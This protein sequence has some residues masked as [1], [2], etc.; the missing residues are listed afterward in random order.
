VIILLETRALAEV[1]MLAMCRDLR[2]RLLWTGPRQ[3]GDWALVDVDCD[4]VIDNLDDVGR[5]HVQTK[6]H[7]GHKIVKKFGTF[8]DAFLGPEIEVLEEAERG[9]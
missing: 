3:G 4:A 8:F 7:R 1:D 6:C 9:M 5:T 2:Q